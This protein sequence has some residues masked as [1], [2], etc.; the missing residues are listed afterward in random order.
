MLTFLSAIS[1]LWTQA[2]RLWSPGVVADQTRQF[3]E[4]VQEGMEA[5]N[6]PESAQMVESFFDSM[7][8]E[9]SADKIRTSAIIMLIYESLTLFGAYLMWG[10]QKRGFHLYLAG[11]AVA[12][13]GPI[14]LI[15]GWLGGMTAFGGAFFSIIFAFLYRSQLKYMV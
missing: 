8:D 10:L 4:R 9:L 3:F 5:Q 13:L 7:Y 14:V 12:I 15:G 6:N 11:V 1:G 2:D